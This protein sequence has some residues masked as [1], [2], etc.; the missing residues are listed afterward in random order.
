[1]NY[2]GSRIAIEEFSSTNPDEIQPVIEKYPVGKTVTLFHN[3]KKPE[4][5]IIELGPKPP[6]FHR[7]SLG[8]AS[9]FFVFA[10]L[11]ANGPTDVNKIKWCVFVGAPLTDEHLFPDVSLCCKPDKSL[12]PGGRIK[13]RQLGGFHTCWTFNLFRMMTNFSL[14]TIKHNLTFTRNDCP[15]LL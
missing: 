11:F 15:W 12:I 1:V 8:L 9:F 6:S 4:E 13:E 5:S 2:E 7:I 14:T 10:A 3:P